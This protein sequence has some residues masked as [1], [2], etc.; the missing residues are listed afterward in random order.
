MRVLSICATVVALLGGNGNVAIAKHPLPGPHFFHCSS[1]GDTV[2]LDWDALGIPSQSV[3]VLLFRDD[4]LLSHVEADDHGYEDLDVPPGAHVYRLSIEGPLGFRESL[5][6]ETVVPEGIGLE[7]D[8]AEEIVSIRW[9]PLPVADLDVILRVDVRRDDEVVAELAPDAQSYH[10]M[11]PPG[12][13]R[14]ML[15][16]IWNSLDPR[17][18]LF[19]G[20]CTVTV[21]ARTSFLRGDCNEDG[22]VDV[23]D[24]VCILA[25]LFQG[26]A[27][28]GCRAAA[29]TNGDAQEDISDAIHLLDHLFLGG[30]APV[31]P[32]PDCGSGTLP[33]DEETCGTP[34]ETCTP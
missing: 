30:P 1:W 17:P 5:E 25:W 27:T 26:R 10:E 15:F 8:V 19:V 12:E 16:G 6:C 24:A 3:E 21:G 23:S 14:Y 32:F 20:S 29:N 7:C 33:T 13:H 31:A 11:P 22:G 4:E 9:G 2:R 28:P 34:P 18:P